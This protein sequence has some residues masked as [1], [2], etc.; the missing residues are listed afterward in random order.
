MHL[1]V[2]VRVPPAPE[3]NI[4]SVLSQT[5]SGA[6]PLH[7]GSIL[8]SHVLILRFPGDF[9]LDSKRSLPSSRAWECCVFLI[10]QDGMYIYAT[11][12][13]AIDRFSFH[14]GQLKTLAN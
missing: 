6:S 12:N 10:L 14:S 13:K 7:T 2:S 8:A 3:T 4:D 9:Q 11:E 5:V 1:A